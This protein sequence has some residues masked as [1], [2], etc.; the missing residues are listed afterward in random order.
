MAAMNNPRMTKGAPRLRSL[1]Q[2]GRIA[3]YFLQSCHYPLLYLQWV[4]C[5]S[6][7]EASCPD[8]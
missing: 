3:L 6:C 1:E 4:Q 8:K 7:D 5:Q 2:V